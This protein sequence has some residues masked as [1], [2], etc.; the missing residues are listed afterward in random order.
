MIWNSLNK[1]D[2]S[3]PPKK[4]LDGQ[5]AKELERGMKPVGVLGPWAGLG[6]YTRSA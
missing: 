3:R 1:T 6:Q 4:P 2:K 5:A